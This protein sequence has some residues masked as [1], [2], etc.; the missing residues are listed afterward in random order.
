[1]SE[2]NKNPFSQKEISSTMEELEHLMT[3]PIKKKLKTLPEMVA[4][5]EKLMREGKTLVWV[6]GCFD[7]V[8]MGHLKYL[9]CG[10]TY[11]DVLLVAMNCDESIRKL[12]GFQRPIIDEATRIAALAHISLVDYILLFGDSP[13]SELKVLQPDVYLKGN[14]YTLDTIN[15]DE[16]KLVQSYGGRVEITPTKVDST[17]NI[18]KRITDYLK[19]LYDS[20]TG[21]FDLS[22]L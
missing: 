11:G 10:K 12:K 9:A 1:M 19:T 3:D 14:D 7:L 17:T 2:E 20:Q 5:R 13:M 18:L 22:K 4:I 8:H 15:Q 16:K 21:E 6:N